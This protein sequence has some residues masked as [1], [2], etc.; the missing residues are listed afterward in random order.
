M[1]ELKLKPRK[2]RHVIHHKTK[3]DVAQKYKYLIAVL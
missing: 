1:G 3:Y 2:L